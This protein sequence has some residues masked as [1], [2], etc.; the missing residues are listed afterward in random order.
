[1]ILSNAVVL[2][3]PVINMV[4]LGFIDGYR[5]DSFSINATIF[6]VNIICFAF[7]IIGAAG[8]VHQYLYCA[9]KSLRICGILQ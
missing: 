9:A 8:S 7:Y 6:V 5:F 4:Q 1:M 3:V 2:C